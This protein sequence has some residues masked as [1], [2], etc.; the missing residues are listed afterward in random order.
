MTTILQKYYL[1][2]FIVLS[3][4]SFSSQAFVIQE[5]FESGNLAANGWYDLSVNTSTAQSV[6]GNSSLEYTFNPG[7]NANGGMRITIPE[8]DTVYLSYQRMYE[9]GYD[10]GST[11]DFYIFADAG[12]YQAPT[13]TKLTA[14]FEAEYQLAQTTIRAALQANS[15]Y[16]NTWSEV[17]SQEN[18][19]ETGVWHH[20]EAM[21]Q[22]NDP[23]ESNGVMRMWVDGEL[24]VERVGLLL[25]AAGDEDI[26][27][28]QVFFG[29]WIDAGAP[30]TQKFFTDD[31]IISD[32]AITFAE[33][34][35]VPIPAAYLLFGF[36]MMTLSRFR[37]A[38]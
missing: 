37:T 31:V 32:Q 18:V 14:Y 27:F 30:Q 36:A 38:A 3:T 7:Q 10:F 13:T 16:N 6:S 23:G 33:P 21:V 9:D 24:V 4:L 26:M 12:L 1:L 2:S 20:I 22:M 28:N 15:P 8:T 11:H 34:A 29:P 25:R 35:P 19:F 17:R 5:D